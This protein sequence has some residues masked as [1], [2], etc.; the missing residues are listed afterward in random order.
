M[1]LIFILVHVLSDD[2]HATPLPHSLGAR[3]ST[4]SCDDI[5]SRRKL[6]DI[7]WG[8]F[9][10]IFACTWVS[11]HPN[12]PSPD[13][14]W[15]ALFWRRMKMMLIGIIAPEIMVGFAVRQFL[16]ARML[17]KEYGFSKTHGFFFIMGG[18][19]SST[20]YPI[21]TVNQL[22]DRTLGPEFQKAIGDVNTEDIM[23]KSKGDALSKG[24]ALAQGLWFITQCVAR[25]QQGLAVTELEV[26]TLAFAVVN[27]FI[28][29]L[30]WNK[31][32]DVQ[33]AIVV[34]PPKI[35]GA[36]PII[37]VRLPHSELFLTAILGTNMVYEPLSSTSVPSFW[38]FPS[39]YFE[40][41]IKMGPVWFTSF[42]GTLFG[43]IH[44][45]AWNTDF[46]SPAEMWM[47]R[48]CSP[49][50]AAIPCLISVFGSISPT[51]EDNVFVGILLTKV[52]SVVV[53]LMLYVGIPIY[54]A[55]RVIL[56][57]LPLMALRSLPPSAFRDVNWSIYIPHV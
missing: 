13:Q 35:P 1:L 18:F 37:N 25:V 40:E 21:A 43:A 30:W 36:Q 52:I 34:G 17:S 2:S 46:P 11:V 49:V 32:L 44:C 45:A 7:I 3:T 16:G 31:P 8:C 56:I 12:V 28:W 26:A 15:L 9:A 27:I 39:E 23:D 50:I 54:I 42:V 20:G 24:V 14:S 19:I 47:W 55:A 10:T 29:L 41:N 33:R 4:D 5:D 51:I 22:Q 53:L 6:F 57:V 48:Y 38:S